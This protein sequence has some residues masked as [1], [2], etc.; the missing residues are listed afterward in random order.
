MEKM[1]EAQSYTTSDIYE[2]MSDYIHSNELKIKEVYIPS[3]SI[4]FNKV[5]DHLNVF[6]LK[7]PRTKGDIK[8][9]E[10]EKDIVDEL[11]HIIELNQQLEKCKQLIIPKTK[12]Y[13]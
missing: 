9:I 5:R 4:G 10:I 13:L 8:T 6:T 1:I 11:Q 3:Y 2:S 7:K 12:I